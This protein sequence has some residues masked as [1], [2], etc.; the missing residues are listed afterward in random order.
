M[1]QSLFSGECLANS[2]RG[3]WKQLE[4][5]VR[6]QQSSGWEP[7]GATRS[8]CLVNLVFSLGVCLLLLVSAAHV[9]QPELCGTSPSLS[10]VYNFILLWML[11]LL[12]GNDFSY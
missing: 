2:T 3:L 12:T 4:I 11:I 5:V 6:K 9:E 1:Q 10:P 8:W 7:F